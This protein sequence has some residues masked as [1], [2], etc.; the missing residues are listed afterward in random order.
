MKSNEASGEGQITIDKIHAAGDIALKIRE[1]YNTVLKTK[2]A[3][4]ERKGA[5]I[6]MII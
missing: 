5:I 2:N 3:P 4:K 1:L 6:A